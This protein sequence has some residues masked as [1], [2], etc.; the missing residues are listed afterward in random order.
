MVSKPGLVGGSEFEP[1]LA[2]ESPFV[3]LKV[4]EELFGLFDS[5]CAGMGPHVREGVEKHDI[6]FKPKFYELE[7]LGS[8]SF[9]TT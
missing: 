9:N 6:H 5:P 7:L 2:I 8:W 4:H 1:S 3:Y